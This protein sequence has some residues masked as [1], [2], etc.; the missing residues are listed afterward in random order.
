MKI[1]QKDIDAVQ[2]SLEAAKAEGDQ[3]AVRVLV[4]MLN[5]Y[6]HRRFT[7][8]MEFLK[9]EG[10]EVTVVMLKKTESGI[11]IFKGVNAA[12]L[13]EY[14]ADASITEQQAEAIKVWSDGI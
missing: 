3:D 2:K 7:Q 13:S 14:V 12:K 5:N 9:D 4:D 1:T 10:F 6:K 11:V 8:S